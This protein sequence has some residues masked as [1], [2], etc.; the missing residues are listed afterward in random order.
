MCVRTH[1][2]AYIYTAHANICIGEKTRM[3]KRDQR[4]LKKTE[5]GVLREAF[6]R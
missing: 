3:R 1:A 2:C 6:S 4:L 5:T